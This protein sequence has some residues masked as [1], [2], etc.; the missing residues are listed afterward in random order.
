[1]TTRTSYKGYPI[2]F[3]TEHVEREGGAWVIIDPKFTT[4][5]GEFD[6]FEECQTFVDRL[7]IMGLS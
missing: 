4:N 7:E 2:Y 3:T 5:F 1:M 6:S